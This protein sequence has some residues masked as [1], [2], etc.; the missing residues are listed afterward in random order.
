[1]LISLLVACIVVGLVAYIVQQFLPE[2][3]RRVALVILAVILVIYL[4]QFLT[5]LRLP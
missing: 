5:P 1:M 2:P 3:Y 4:L